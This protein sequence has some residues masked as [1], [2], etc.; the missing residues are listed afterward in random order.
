MSDGSF[1]INKKKFCITLKDTA[2]IIDLPINGRAISGLDITSLAICEQYLRM[3]LPF[4]AKLKGL[5]R[6]DI[7]KENFMRV[8]DEI[9]AG[10]NRLAYNVRATY[11]ISLG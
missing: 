5:T 10:D 7:F 4:D 2:Y 6:M 1:L 9:E 11:Y 8:P 3:V